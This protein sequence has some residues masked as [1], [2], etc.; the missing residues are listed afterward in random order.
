[1]CPIPI[2]CTG[3]NSGADSDAEID[4][5]SGTDSGADSGVDTGADF[6]VDSG[7]D[8]RVDSGADSEVDSGADFR[9]VSRIDPAIRIGSGSSSA[10]MSFIPWV[11]NKQSVA[12]L[13]HS[14]NQTLPR[15]GNR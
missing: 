1:M 15:R 3:I 8:F 11:Q 9:V 7:A 5:D 10:G 6:R 13:K 4:S 14:A 2:P 12:A